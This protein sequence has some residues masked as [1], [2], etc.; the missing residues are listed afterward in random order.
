MSE[1]NYNQ[2]GETKSLLNNKSRLKL[3]TISKHFIWIVLWSLILITVDLSSYFLMIHILNNISA[4]G[5]HIDIEQIFIFLSSIAIVSII[6]VISWI[7]L[8]FLLNCY[9]N[10]NNNKK[11]FAIR[12][13][14]TLAMIYLVYLTAGVGFLAIISTL[15]YI[16]YK[17]NQNRPSKFRTQANE[18]I[19]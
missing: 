3:N 12:V 11:T 2:S 1:N 16:D 8:G 15:K 7:Y 10:W 14:V 6:N 9:F 13:F 5:K 19:I 18:Q 17:N 4:I